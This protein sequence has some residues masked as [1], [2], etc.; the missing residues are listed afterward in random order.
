MPEKTNGDKVRESLV[1][2]GVTEGLAVG[3]VDILV[4][5]GCIRTEADISIADIK[6]VAN[7]AELPLRTSAPLGTLLLTSDQRIDV[8]HERRHREFGSPAPLTSI[9]ASP[10]VLLLTPEMRVI[11][12][13][14]DRSRLGFR[15]QV[16]ADV[17][18]SR[19][20]RTLH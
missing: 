1:A 18:L 7:V 13:K 6:H 8:G 14:S 4:K 17:A 9:N 19:S 3:I 11:K 20:A 2:A 15:P 16:I 10:K 12:F 5:A